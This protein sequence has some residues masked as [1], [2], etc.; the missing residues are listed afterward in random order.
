MFHIIVLAHAPVQSYGFL[1]FFCGQAWISTV[2]RAEGI[3]RASFDI[4]LGSPKE[5][6]RNC[7]DLLTPAGFGPLRCVFGVEL[8]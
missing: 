8:S 1:E 7:M 2:M 5:G 4:N 3:Q 6:K